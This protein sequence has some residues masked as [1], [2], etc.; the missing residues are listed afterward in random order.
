M[1][2]CLNFTMKNSTLKFGMTYLLQNDPGVADKSLYAHIVAPCYRCVSVVRLGTYTGKVPIY[3]ALNAVF[4][5]TG[6]TK[7]FGQAR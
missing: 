5:A 3:N 4:P 6:L 1:L 7:Y 2:P